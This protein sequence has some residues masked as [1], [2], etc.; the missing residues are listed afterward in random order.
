MLTRRHSGYTDEHAPVARDFRR[1]TAGLYIDRRRRLAG[2]HHR[3][4][5]ELP[6]ITFHPEDDGRV[7]FVG[8]FV[9]AHLRREAFR[10]AATVNHQPELGM[11]AEA[12]RKENPIEL[13]R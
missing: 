2:M 10:R 7:L 11:A 6:A 1:K 8:R 4:H 9:D 5:E 12:I 3:T 13:N